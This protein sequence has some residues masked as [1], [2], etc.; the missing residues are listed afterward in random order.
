MDNVKP[1]YIHAVKG[2]VPLNLHELWEYRELVGFMLW[3]DIKGRYKQTAFGPLWMLVTPIINMIVFTIIFSRV[4]RL[5]SD[6]I[7]YPL[8]NY[9]ALLPWGFFSRCLFAT[10]GSLLTNKD[11]LS[12]VYFPRLI[13][14]LVGVVSALVDF[15]ISFF[16]LLG[17]LFYYGYSP[18]WKAL[19]IPLFLLLAAITGVGVGLW[20]AAMVVHFRDLNTVLSYLVKVWM[21]ATPV[22]YSA[23]LVPAHWHTLYYLNP[24]THVVDGMRWA[25]LGR[26][27]PPLNL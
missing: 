10:A 18:G 11:L 22:V 24:I 14:P 27:L 13:T 6:G 20:C 4:A 7:P 1:T 25:L 9:T 19:A 3:R 21:Y 8:F 2:L 5:P 17:L 26:P 12:K 15:C 23:T 16:I